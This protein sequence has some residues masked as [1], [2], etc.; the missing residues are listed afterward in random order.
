[1]AEGKRR[2]VEALKSLLIC[3]L[4]LSA[5]FLSSKAFVPYGGRGEEGEL[6]QLPHASEEHQ[7]SVGVSRPVRMA[8]VNENGRYGV[9]YDDD[10]VDAL[11]DSLGDLL[12]EALNSAEAAL[13]V[14]RAVWEQALLSRGIYCDF[15]GIVSLPLLSAWLGE[16]ETVLEG[17]AVSLLLTAGEEG[18]T[19]RLYYSDPQ[20]MYYTCDTQVWFGQRL[21]EY[22]PNGAL[23]A[24]QQ[25]EHYGGLAPDTLILPDVPA[26]PVYSSAAGVNVQDSGALEKLLDALAFSPQPNAI[27]PAADGWNVREAEDSLRLTRTGDIYYHAGENS[28]RYP[29]PHEAGYTELVELTG[30]LVRRTMAPYCG[31]ARLYLDEVAGDGESW[32]VTYRY[33]LSG[34]ETALGQEGWCARFI[35]AGGQIREYTLKLRRYTATETKAVLLPEYQAMY[36]MQAMEA[37]GQ[38][39]LLRYY[40]GGSGAVSPAWIAR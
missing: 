8:V 32:T 16:G 7:S 25:P 1:M 29:V 11:F 27:Y 17:Q 2:A 35:I 40:D 28:D 19:A 3:L 13:P 36:A 39:L 18:D 4:V 34:A 37:E 26:P 23:F 31:A 24:F 22:V 15:P 9:Q 5:L 6:D 21:D 38:L 33:A 12:G 20:G 30:E 10:A 14:E